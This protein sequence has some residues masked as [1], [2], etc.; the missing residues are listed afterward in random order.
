MSSEDQKLGADWQALRNSK[1][2]RALTPAEFDALRSSSRIYQFPSD[3]VL[4]PQAEIPEFLVF[5]L[6][7][8]VE[9]SA[10]EE[11]ASATVA[12]VGAG[13]ALGLGSVIENLPTLTEARTTATTRFAMI[14]AS[15]VR[16]WVDT[17]HAFCKAV[18]D[19]VA[20]VSRDRVMKLHGQKLRTTTE[21]LALWLLEN[22]TPAG[23]VEIPF[24][25][26]TLAFILGTT[27]ENLAR[28]FASL[29]DVVRKLAFKKYEVVDLD[30]LTEI[31]RPSPLVKVR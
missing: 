8:G 15:L 29:A 17:N 30:R 7:G 6:D 26:R 28:A 31:A 12:V 1:L 14:P 22:R 5:V 11:K 9:L 21:R 13:S 25:K 27:P 10:H 23:L 20:G 19:N 3:A 2:F 18:I 16:Q 24:E 4:Q